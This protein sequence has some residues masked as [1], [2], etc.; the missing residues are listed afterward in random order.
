MSITLTPSARTDANPR[1]IVAL[2]LVQGAAQGR[3]LNGKIYGSRESGQEWSRL[4]PIPRAQ[5]RPNTRHT[6][7]NPTGSHQYCQILRFVAK[8]ATF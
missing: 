4:S 3:T 2:R 5:T 1:G 7:H 8:P 6:S